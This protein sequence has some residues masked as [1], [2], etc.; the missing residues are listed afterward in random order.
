MEHPNYFSEDFDNC[1]Y[2]ENFKFKD[3]LNAIKFRWLFFFF[4]AHQNQRLKWAFPITWRLSS[5]VHHL[6]TFH[7]M[8]FFLTT[9]W[10]NW[11]NFRCDTPWM[12]LFQNYVRWPCSTSSMPSRA[13]NWL[14]KWKSFKIFFRTSPLDEMKEIWSKYSLD[15]RTIMVPFQNCVRWPLQLSKIIKFSKTSNFLKHKCAWVTR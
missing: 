3:P 1:L 7:I 12:V 15:G 4:L 6:L 14:K 2:S 10:P 13:S 11:T 5:D 9:I 8:I